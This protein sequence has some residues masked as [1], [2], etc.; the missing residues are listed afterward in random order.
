MKYSPYDN[1][2]SILIVRIN[3]SLNYII[4]RIDSFC[5]FIY[6]NDNEDA[7]KYYI[8][9][10]FWLGEYL[11]LGSLNHCTNIKKMF[12]I[13]PTKT[14]ERERYIYICRK[15]IGL[16]VEQFLFESDPL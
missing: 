5:C 1:T 8:P 16:Q 13:Y 2:H 14:S 3:L 10:P 11:I 15:N 12:N 6:Q 9:P 4:D 7:L